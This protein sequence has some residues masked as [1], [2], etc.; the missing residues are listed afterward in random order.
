MRRISLVLLV[1]AWLSSAAVAAECA[2]GKQFPQACVSVSQNSTPVVV[3]RIKG[4]VYNNAFLENQEGACIGLF[5]DADKSLVASVETDKHGGFKLPDVPEGDY[6]LLVRLDS[7]SLST[8]RLQLRKN[9]SRKWLDIRTAPYNEC[10]AV[11]LK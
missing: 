8:L 10:F 1:F 5:R 3:R 2:A 11:T 9:G 7:D 6:L 4:G